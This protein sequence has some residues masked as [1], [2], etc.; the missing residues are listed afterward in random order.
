MAESTPKHLVG[1]AELPPGMS[2]AKYFEKLDLLE[3]GAFSNRRAGSSQPT[4][5]A[6]RGWREKS[7]D[8][9]RFSV[10][11]HAELTGAKA[12]PVDEPGRETAASLADSCQILAAEAAVFRS[13]ASFSPS[14]QNRERMKTFFTEVATAEAFGDTVRVWEPGGLWEP[15]G[16]AEIAEHCGVL[17]A[18]DP[19]GHDPLDERTNFVIEQLAKGQAYLR[20]TGIGHSRRRFDSYR[21]EMLAEMLTDLERSWTLFAHPGMYPDALA[22]QRELQTASELE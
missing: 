2:R 8:T 13:P 17:V 10:L 15:P 21:L 20:V 4:R 7:P 14:A 16:I 5:K 6:V 9:A 11:A 19:L 18:I 12:F 3:I 1:C 22:M